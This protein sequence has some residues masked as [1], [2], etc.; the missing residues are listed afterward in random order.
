[1]EEALKD[2]AKQ[3]NMLVPNQKRLVLSEDTKKIVYDIAQRHNLNDQQK[4]ILFNEV[5]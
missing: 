2:L 1:M 3:F 4:T 5:I